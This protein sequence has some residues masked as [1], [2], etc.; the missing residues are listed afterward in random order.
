MNIMMFESLFIFFFHYFTIVYFSFFTVLVLQLTQFVR[1]YL[2]LLLL[3][4]D[5][6]MKGWLV[7]PLNLILFQIRNV[8]INATEYGSIKCLSRASN[9][10]Q[11][12]LYL[13]SMRFIMLEKQCSQFIICTFEENVHLKKKI[14][15][16]R[17]TIIL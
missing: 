9:W 1:L 15:R 10:R 14:S 7:F 17:I 4:C 3:E 11:W 13:R 5:T 2:W 16:T 6:S 8:S 12:M